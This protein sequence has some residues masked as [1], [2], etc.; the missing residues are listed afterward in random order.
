MRRL[1]LLRRRWRIEGLL[2]CGLLALAVGLVVWAVLHW[3]WGWPWWAGIFV[4]VVVWG[5]LMAVFPVWRL[6]LADIA[7]FLDGRLPELE[8]SCGLLLR[9]AGELS[10]LERLQVARVE[11]RFGRLEMPRPFRRRLLLAAG[12]LGL[13]VL[14]SMGLGWLG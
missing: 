12:W 9:P 13:A 8:E 4:W 1:D 3:L 14:V 11:E 7:V 5:V 6:G 10:G 2:Y